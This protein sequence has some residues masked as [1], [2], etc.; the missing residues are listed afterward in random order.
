[1]VCSMPAALPSLTVEAAEQRDA[2]SDRVH[3]STI[4]EIPCARMT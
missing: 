2:A 3:I 4:P 1:M